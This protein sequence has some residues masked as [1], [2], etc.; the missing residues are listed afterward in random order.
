[1]LYTHLHH[2]FG[3]KSGMYVPVTLEIDGEMKFY[4][5]ARGPPLA[6]ATLRGTRLCQ[7]LGAKKL[8]PKKS[9]KKLIFLFFVAISKTRP[10]FD[11]D[12]FFRRRPSLAH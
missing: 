1:M 4:R 6:R 3:G 9:K 2:G 11:F 12:H 10:I 7:I 8:R 5:P